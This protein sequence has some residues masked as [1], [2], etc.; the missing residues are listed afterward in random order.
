MALTV[1]QLMEWGKKN[2]SD[3]RAT[4]L[5]EQVQ[6]GAF[7]EQARNE[8]FD[9]TG[10]SQSF[11]VEAPEAVEERRTGAERV[12]GF[13]QKAGK[14]LG[15]EK[16]GEG[17]G[18]TLAA[19]K[20]AET[21]EQAI[22]QVTGLQTQLLSRLEEAQEQGDEARVG[23]LKEALGASQDALQKASDIQGGFAEDTVS[24]REVIGSAINL[25]TLALGAGAGARAAQV[26][27]KGARI[28]ALAATG[29]AE[30]AAFTTGT[31]LAEE[32][33]LPTGG[34]LVRGAALGAAIP[35][36][37]AALGPVR[38]ALGKITGRAATEITGLSTGTSQETIQSAF[39]VVKR[40]GKDADEFKK[41]LRGEVSPEQLVTN[42]RETI[43]NV[44]VNR[45]VAF[46][47][48]LTELGEETVKTSD[49]GN[50]FIN[51][52][53]EFGI[54]VTDEGLDFTNSKLRTSSSA[55]TKIN[56]AFDEMQNLA[57]KGET[58]IKDIDTTRQA[59]GDRK[60]VV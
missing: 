6:A 31:T 12:A 30:G 47:E 36:G 34:E 17:L 16:F 18:Q 37:I 29:A 9:L 48:S 56:Q 8:G 22:E 58:N 50:Q 40:G 51:K 28:G 3:P 7:D 5:R 10:K 13:Q 52:L 33:R 11:T 27:G 45:D 53:D 35:G 43:D 26:A 60:S 49:T 24:S 19:G 14:F 25:A 42:V 38:R 46:R 44:K 41:A 57:N 39:D 32:E 23:R 21:G 15:I 59:L 2:P 54:K 4:K 20:I 1:Q 55:Q